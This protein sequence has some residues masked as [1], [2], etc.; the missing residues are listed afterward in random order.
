M[1]WEQVDKYYLKGKLGDLLFTI[2]KSMIYDK[3]IYELW[4][5]SKRLYKTENIEDAKREA[6]QY[7]K[8]QSTSPSSKAK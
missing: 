1:K 5:G 7:H 6:I 2:S 3:V 4:N 8:E